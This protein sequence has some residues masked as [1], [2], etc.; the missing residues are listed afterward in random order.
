MA[1]LAVYLMTVDNV[2]MQATASTPPHE[3]SCAPASS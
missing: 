2:A 1:H 3:T